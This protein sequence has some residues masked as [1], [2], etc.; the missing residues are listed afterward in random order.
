MDAA[1]QI[2]IPVAGIVAAAAVTFYVVSFAE[3]REVKSGKKESLRYRRFFL[4]LSDYFVAI[5]SFVIF[6]PSFSGFRLLLLGAE[7]AQGAG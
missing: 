2:A 6:T 7:I 5:E 1:M 4:V 3:I